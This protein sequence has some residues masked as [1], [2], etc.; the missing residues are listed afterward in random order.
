MNNEGVKLKS[1]AAMTFGMTSA[2]PR[3]E[4]LPRYFYFNDTFVLFIKEKKSSK[5]YFALR[6][7][8]INNFQ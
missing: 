3:A 5:P 6:V 8:D 4:D 1:E 7:H 2:G